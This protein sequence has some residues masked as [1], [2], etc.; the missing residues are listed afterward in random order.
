MIFFIVIL[1]FYIGVEVLINW[2]DIYIIV[3][4][5]FRGKLFFFV[6]LERYFIFWYVE[7]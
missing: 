1:I 6:N 5:G 4:V 7:V 3:I 2:F